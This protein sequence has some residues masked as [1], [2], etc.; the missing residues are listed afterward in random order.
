[1]VSARLE[2][3]TFLGHPKSKENVKHATDWEIGNDAPN[4]EIYFLVQFILEQ[5]NTTSTVNVVVKEAMVKS[6]SL[7]DTL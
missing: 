2:D 3:P 5:E 4:L 7:P 1:M 6:L